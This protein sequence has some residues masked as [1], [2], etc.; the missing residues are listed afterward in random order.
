M[1]CDRCAWFRVDD[2]LPYCETLRGIAI[3]T[4]GPLQ[5]CDRFVDKSFLLDEEEKDICSRCKKKK[6]PG[7]CWWCGEDI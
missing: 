7:K 6:D 2:A 3:S 4:T 5:K 1:I